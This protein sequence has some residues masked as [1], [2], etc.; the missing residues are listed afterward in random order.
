MRRLTQFNADILVA[1]TLNEYRRIASAADGYTGQIHGAETILELPD[2]QIIIYG[3][4]PG[5]VPTLIQQ[6]ADRF[7]PYTGEDHI[8]VGTEKLPEIASLICVYC[9]QPHYKIN[10]HRVGLDCTGPPTARQMEHIVIGLQSLTDKLRNLQLEMETFSD[11]IQNAI[12]Q[13]NVS[14]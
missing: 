2:V 9:G 14:S 10:V 5:Q 8:T 12:F 3:P 6:L 11:R 7:T 13:H 1:N 4:P